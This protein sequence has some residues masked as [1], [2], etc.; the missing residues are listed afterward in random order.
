MTMMARKTTPKLRTK[1]RH[2]LNTGWWLT[3]WTDHSKS[4]NAF[5]RHLYCFVFPLLFTSFTSF[6]I[7]FFYRFLVNKNYHNS[8][9]NKNI[10]TAIRSWPNSVRL[11][12]HTTG[13]VKQWSLSI[14]NSLLH[15]RRDDGRALLTRAPEAI[16][17]VWRSPY[18]SWTLMGG[19]IPIISVM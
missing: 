9:L 5:V 2:E 15:L 10:A 13:V 18:Q 6:I 3:V 8:Y 14:D 16:W 1:L 12:R 19:A 17:Q 7:L 11:W 4:H